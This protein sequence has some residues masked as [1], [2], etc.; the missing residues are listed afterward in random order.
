MF[1]PS[2]KTL[3]SMLSDWWSDDQP[4]KQFMAKKGRVTRRFFLLFISIGPLPSKSRV[5]RF[6]IFNTPAIID[7]P[8]PPPPSIIFR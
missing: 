3:N 5:C 2:L 4:W 6:A 7:P 8:P 1:H